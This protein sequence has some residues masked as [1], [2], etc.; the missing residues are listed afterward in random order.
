[1]FTPWQ[2]VE[3]LSP[4]CSIQAEAAFRCDR[5]Y[6]ESYWLNSFIECGRI[7]KKFNEKKSKMDSLKKFQTWWFFQHFLCHLFYSRGFLLSR[8][9]VR[10]PFV[11]GRA[12]LAA[13]PQ[14][15][16]FLLTLL[17]RET[18]IVAFRRWMAPLATSLRQGSAFAA[19]SRRRSI[20]IH[21]SRRREPALSF[22]QR[23]TTIIV[24][25]FFSSEWQLSLAASGPRSLATGRRGRW[26]RTR[27]GRNLSL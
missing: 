3:I 16:P 12:C 15:G 9:S 26:V 6:C 2:K 1:M 18:P 17:G 19:S 4:K 13:A 23:H 27:P 20:L 7:W 8:R 10:R 21:S 22:S 5:S 25:P 24:A 11:R 14:L